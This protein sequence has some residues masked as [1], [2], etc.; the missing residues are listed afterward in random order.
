M[1]HDNTL[2]FSRIETAMTA[3]RILKRMGALEIF[4]NDTKKRGGRKFLLNGDVFY[5]Y[6]KLLKGGC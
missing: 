6:V 3:N 2:R 5:V 4:D 1:R